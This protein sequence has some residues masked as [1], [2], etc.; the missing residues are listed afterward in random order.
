MISRWRWVIPVVSSLMLIALSQPVQA[1]LPGIEDYTNERIVP[2]LISPTSAR[3]DGSGFLYSPRIVFTSA[4]TAVTFDS[5]G[6]MVDFRAE[7][8]VGK[9]NS[10]VTNS[11]TGVRVIKRFASPGYIADKE[12]DIN[13]FAILVLERDLMQIQPAQ[14]MTPE[15]E[16]ELV[17]KKTTVKMHGYGN[18]VDLCGPNE[19]PPC[20]TGRLDSSAVPR[21]A[22]ATLRTASDFAQLIPRPISTRFVNELLFFSPEKTGM[23]AGDSGGSLTTT[24]N[25]KLLYLSNIGTGAFTYGCGMGGGYDGKGGFQYS[26]QI[27]KQLDL[28]KQAESF[29]A[30]QIAIE[31]ATAKTKAEAEEKV[32]LKARADAEA[33]IAAEIKAKQ[34]AEA[35]TAGIK[36]TTISCVKGKLI[37][38]VSAVKPKCPAGYK[39]K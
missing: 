38:K 32:E 2:L 31:L 28:I 24:Y 1:S 10:N 4:H 23:C 20:K 25:G 11:G 30:E 27:Y 14:L 35:K 39:K 18:Y 22:E 7:L 29:V 13:D 12:G 6:R 33:K 5:N 16:K 36:K 34:E 37:K 26:P 9:P 21:S 15:I 17:G 8:S 19:I 3:A